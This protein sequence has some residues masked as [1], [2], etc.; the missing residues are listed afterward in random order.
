MHQNEKKENC[1]IAKKLKKVF[2]EWIDNGHTNIPAFYIGFKFL[3]S[4][5]II[6]AI[7]FSRP[8]SV[9]ASRYARV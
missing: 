2:A 4:L 5:S 9:F 8:A 7:R 3:L 6:Q 1:V